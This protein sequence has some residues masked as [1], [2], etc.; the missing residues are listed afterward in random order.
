MILET[1]LRTVFKP[2]RTPAE[3]AFLRACRRQPASRIPVWLMRQAGRYLPEFRRLHEKY[4]FAPLVRTPELACAITL[5]PVRAF[6]LD[7]AIIF[8]DIIPLLE[9]LG[10]KFETGPG[11][12]PVALAPVRT[13]AQVRELRSV[14]PE[15]SIG[16]TLEAI[17][18]VLPELGADNV[19]LIGFGA[20]PF[21]LACYAI[22]GGS[23]AIFPITKAFMMSQQ[24]AWHQL[25]SKLSV[26]VGESLLAQA[27]AGAQV[28][29]LFDTWVG[30]LGL[31]DYRNYVFRYT[32]RA[33]QIARSANVPIIHF[34]SGNSC[35]LEEMCATGADV[36]GLDWRIDLDAAWR[37]IGRGFAV[38]GNLDPVALLAPWGALKRQAHR[39][40]NQ[41]L[42]VEND[43]A[44]Y[45]FSLGHGVLPSTSTSNVQ[46]LVD[47]VHEYPLTGGRAC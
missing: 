26:A 8:S 44:G 22:E 36:I 1:N 4:G 17:R 7:A 32:Q 13:A 2:C 10:L 12:E 23:S 21:T 14:P 20:A 6:G 38:Q 27:R 41:A 28:L 39:V 35:L 16:Y 29:H 33:I 5:L 40:L 9:G 42:A 11:V 43:G 31:A 45:I 37:R 34:A 25:M 18:M 46:R 30:T 24:S 47:L 15:E 19:P 3:S